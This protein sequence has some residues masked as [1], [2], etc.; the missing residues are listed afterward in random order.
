MTGPVA[1]AARVVMPLVAAAGLTAAP[2]AP[3]RRP[4]AGTSEAP[5]E[6]AGTH[7]ARQGIGGD[8]TG[9]AS[10]DVSGDG[11]IVAFVSMRR[12]TGADVNAIDDIYTLDRTTGAIALESVARTGSANGSNQQPRIS[13]DGRVV[14]FA[15]M[16]SNLIGAAGGGPVASQVMRRDRV[17]GTTTLVSHTPAGGPGNGWS[18]QADVS[19]DGRYVVFESQATD[20]VP[21][22]D[23][24]HGGSDVYLYDA[25]DGAVRRVSLTDAGIQSASGQS[26][27]PAIDAAGRVIAFAST[28]PLDGPARARPNDPIRSIFRRDLATGE[29]RRLSASHGGGVP[30]GASFYPAISGDGRRTVF[31][32]VASNLVAGSGRTRR[33]QLYLHDAGTGVLRHISRTLTGGS[34]DGANRYPAVSGDGRFVAFSSEASDLPCADR[35][36]P[37]PDRNLVSDVYRLDITTGAVDRVSGGP[38]TREAWWTPSAGAAIDATGRI[39]AF[40]SRQP[41]DEADL[42]DDDDVFLA[43]LPAAAGQDAAGPSPAGPNLN[44]PNSA[45]VPCAAVR[46]RPPIS[47]P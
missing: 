43:V 32:S 2:L 33:P 18:G 26:G 34:T 7:V 23:A 13:A 35:C 40:S 24:N 39:V 22:P 36:G 10:V 20:L 30:D 8:V 28:A 16:A 17:T 6:A 46:N 27:T 12:L 19:G 31:V 1:S 15:S 38:G 25:S 3:G 44:G 21:G 47:L 41:V 45:A 37:F 4:A 42:E 29:T 9:A 14:V 11:R 5:C